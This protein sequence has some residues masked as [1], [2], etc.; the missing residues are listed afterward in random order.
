VNGTRESSAGCLEFPVLNMEIRI[1]SEEDE[2][3]VED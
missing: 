1:K 3:E 2:E